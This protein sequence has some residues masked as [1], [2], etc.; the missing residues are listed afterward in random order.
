MD[1]QLLGQVERLR[2][3]MNSAFRA[4]NDMLHRE[5]LELSRSLDELIL[6][7]QLLKWSRTR[8]KLDDQG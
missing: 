2:H 1:K 7:V 8:E 6:Q 4:R 5:V 3:Q